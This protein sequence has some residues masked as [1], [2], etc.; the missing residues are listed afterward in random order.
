MR[1][2]SQDES[3][4]YERFEKFGAKALT[5]AELL[6]IIIRTGS[7]DSSPVDIA[8]NVLSLGH[9]REKGLNALNSLSVRELMTINGIGSVK[10]VK[11]K[12]L[13]ELSRRMSLNG[14][15]ALADCSV[16]SE[17]AGRYM[18]TLRH[19]EKEKTM[20]LCLN[21]RLKL[22][23]E[24]LLSIG[25]ANS[26]FISPRDVFIH[27]LKAGACNVVLLHNH[28]GGDP[29]PSRN[30][31]DITNK[32]RKSGMMLDINLLDHIIIGDKTYFSYAEKGLLWS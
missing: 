10:A 7:K 14:M 27:A 19:E 2:V 25:T 17:I 11:L 6:A 3:L 1:Y 24:V 31:T 15:G 16:P 20:V 32:I 26:A 23:D 21:N 22:I 8:K 5:D 18:E 4:P 12:C 29:T 30:D 28:P 9:G 13:A